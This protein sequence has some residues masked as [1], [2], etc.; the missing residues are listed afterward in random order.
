MS[1][2]TVKTRSTAQIL[3]SLRAKNAVDGRTASQLGVPS[4]TLMKLEKDGQIIR[5]GT[6]KIKGKDVILWGIE[7]TVAD[8][9]A[10]LSKQDILDRLNDAPGLTAKDLG[11]S[12]AKMRGM[13][14]LG[15]I[16]QSGSR[17]TGSRGRPAAEFTA[18]VADLPVAATVEVA[19][20]NTTNDPVAEDDV[21]VDISDEDIA[22]A[23]DDIDPLDPEGEA[24]FDSQDL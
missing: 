5:K 11:V 4:G 10:P 14:A 16:E 15:L 21:L 13:E 8:S 17:K 24:F 23:L 1:T 22:A 6:E 2:T 18:L 7:P 9:T 20:E 3:A 12:L 19:E